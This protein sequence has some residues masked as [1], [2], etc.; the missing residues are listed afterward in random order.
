MSVSRPNRRVARAVLAAFA[1]ALLI[2]SVTHLEP[3]REPIEIVVGSGGVRS[4]RSADDPSPRLP[5]E[6]DRPADDRMVRPASTTTTIRVEL[7]GGVAIER[8]PHLPG[9]LFSED[10]VT[11]L[12]DYRRGASA[13]QLAKKYGISKA[14]VRSYVAFWGVRGRHLDG[15]RQWAFPRAAAEGA[16]RARSHCSDEVLGTG[17]HPVSLAVRG[18][19]GPASS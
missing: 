8:A 13:S 11:L 14:L 4:A 6:E 10:I 9:Q 19:A 16:R 1:G 15:P 5:S 18:R 12:D 7:G 17:D 3:D 2:A